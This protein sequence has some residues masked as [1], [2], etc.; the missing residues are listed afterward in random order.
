MTAGSRRVILAVWVATAVAGRAPARAQ[1]VDPGTRSTVHDA[2]AGQAL[3]YGGRFADA[4]QFFTTLSA[5]CPKDAVG[6]A[7][8][9]S[10]LIWEGA[11]LEEDDFQADSVEA[12]LR[13]ASARAEAAIAGAASD[14]AR[15]AQLFW[16]GTALGYRARQAELHGRFWSAASA[17]RK[18]RR[19]LEQAV[20]LDSSCVDCL[21]GL[22]VHDYALARAGV[23]ARLVARLLGLGGGNAAR[24]L[25]QMRRVG[26][27]GTL[28][29]YEAQWVYAN[30]LLRE[31]KKDEALREEAR[32]I[33][34]GLA[35]QFPGNPVFPRFLETTGTGPGAEAAPDLSRSPRSGGIFTP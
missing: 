9:A 2:V 14:S 10:A 17:A 33:V 16:L 30:A 31:S 24:A 13:E 6:P 25:A 20:A 28:T 7:L 8:A 27:D 32:R 1:A 21:L 26:A 11:A 22:A 3:I 12:L 4:A 29:R 23:L 18:M 15:A 35:A 19:A 34:R 5:R